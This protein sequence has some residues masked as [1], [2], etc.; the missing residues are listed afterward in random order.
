M[1]NELDRRFSRTNCD[2]MNSIQA[3]NPKSDVF[4]KETALLSFA[5]LYDS[6]I[7]DLGHEFIEPY[8]DV[9]FELFRLCKI[10]VAIPVSSASCERSFSTLKRVKTCL[11]STITDERLSNLGVLSIES[12]RAK[13]LNMEHFVDRFAKQHKNHRILLL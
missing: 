4:L 1:L 6:D 7:N 8:K 13:A 3:L 5:R 10:A 2:L 11:R 12:K 9:F